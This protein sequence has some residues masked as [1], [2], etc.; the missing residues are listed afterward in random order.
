MKN[1]HKAMDQL[2]A[3]GR[4]I[5]GADVKGKRSLT[6]ANLKDTWLPAIRSV[7]Y[8]GYLHGSIYIYNIMI[9]PTLGKGR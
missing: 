7:G 6:Q 1:L 3:W 2:Y 5:T 4:N 8:L 9:Y